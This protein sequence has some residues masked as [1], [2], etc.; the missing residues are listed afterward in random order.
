MLGDLVEEVVN[1]IKSTDGDTE[2]PSLS[3]RNATLK[4]VQ[5]NGYEELECRQRGV[6]KIYFRNVYNAIQTFFYM[7]S[8]NHFHQSY[9]YHLD[10]VYVHSPEGTIMMAIPINVNLRVSAWRGCSTTTRIVE[11]LKHTLLNRPIEWEKNTLAVGGSISAASLSIG[12]I[13]DNM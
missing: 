13:F 5:R 2:R 10:Q 8:L 7:G 11:L 3:F 9:S 4:V 12:G 1:H 6:G